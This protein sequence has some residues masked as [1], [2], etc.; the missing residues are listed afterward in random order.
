VEKLEKLACR[1][2][3]S[4]KF[5]FGDFGSETFQSHFE[6]SNDTFWG[7]KFTIVAPSPL[8]LFYTLRPFQ[9]CENHLNQSS[10]VEV[11][12]TIS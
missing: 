5:W 3:F 2:H 11:M 10:Y 6:A 4:G 9:W 8:T 1:A 12:P 7:K